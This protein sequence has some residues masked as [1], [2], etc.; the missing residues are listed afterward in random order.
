MP[1]DLR[2]GLE[3]ANQTVAFL[4]GSNQKNAE[5]VSVRS[6]MKALGLYGVLEPPRAEPPDVLCHVHDSSMAKFEVKAIYDQD[7]KVHEEYKKAR[8]EVEAQLKPGAEVVMQ[9]PKGRYGKPWTVPG[10]LPWPRDPITPAELAQ[11]C[12]EWMNVYLKKHAKAYPIEKR[13][14]LDLLFYVNLCAWFPDEGPMPDVTLVEPLGFRSVSAVFDR[15]GFV[16]Q[17]SEKAPE[18]LRQRAGQVFLAF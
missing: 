2:K 17:A 7:R 16:F 8:A 18:F 12:F 4:Q 15:W 6:F 10:V 1:I 11:H 3:R 5:L 13:S 9:G 14:E